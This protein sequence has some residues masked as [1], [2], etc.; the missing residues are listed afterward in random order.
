MSNIII[1]H[2]WVD[3]ITSLQPKNNLSMH[4]LSRKLDITYSHV[5]KLITEFERL[6]WIKTSIKGRE[7]K[8]ELTGK[9]EE[10]KNCFIPVLLELKARR[11][12]Q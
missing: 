8:I 1:F 12:A 10:I 11:G 7:R 3:L 6:N 9:G 5:S 2:K 4:R